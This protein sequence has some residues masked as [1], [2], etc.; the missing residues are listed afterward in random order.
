MT[1][2]SLPEA[3]NFQRRGRDQPAQRVLRSGL[4]GRSNYAFAASG[5]GSPSLS[6]PA[7]SLHRSLPRSPDRLVDG[8]RRGRREY[9]RPAHAPAELRQIARQTMQTAPAVA[10]D[11][12]SCWTAALARMQPPKLP[13]AQRDEERLGRP[14]SNKLSIGLSDGYDEI[15]GACSEASNW[16]VNHPKRI[17][18]ISTCQC[19]SLL[20]GQHGRV[21]QEFPD[22]HMIWR[23]RI[24]FSCIR[25]QMA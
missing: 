5:S 9:Q 10:G 4:I 11:S 21:T 20:S 14:A 3:G 23:H 12:R 13:E 1:S 24:R 18:S 15:F 25:R 2:E 16:F 22:F 8:D 7:P 19:K 6:R 17:R